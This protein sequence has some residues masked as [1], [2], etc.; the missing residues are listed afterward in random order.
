MHESVG[1]Y[2]AFFEA[3]RSRLENSSA[4]REGWIGYLYH[5]TNIE[6]AVSILQ[7][8]LLLSRADVV[9]HGALKRDHADPGVISGTDR[10]VS[11]YVRLY[12]RPR[13][14]TFFHNEGFRSQ[15]LRERNRFNAH[16]PVPVAL[17]FDAATV[18]AL[19]Q[20]RFSDGN[21]ATW[22]GLPLMS[23]TFQG[24]AALESLP[25]EGIYHDDI[26]YSDDPRKQEIIR[27]RNSEVIVPNSLS[28][29]DHLRA[30][31][32]RSDA[33]LRTLTSLSGFRTWERYRKRT[34]INTDASI[35]FSRWLFIERVR[36]VNGAVALNIH[37][38]VE[39]H[40]RSQSFDATITVEFEDGKTLA[41]TFKL[42]P[43]RGSSLQTPT[44]WLPAAATSALITI[45]LDGELAYR[46]WHWLKEDSVLTRTYDSGEH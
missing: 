33:E 11:H 35:F 31:R 29:T 38:P 12:F 24:L 8:G 32:C 17:I 9:T 44:D 39:V 14:P 36:I 10:D 19:P 15:A 1:T 21:L 22:T 26:L 43:E 41:K 18:L 28:L 7:S 46:A 23:R 3:L 30:I 6:N 5:V 25:F 34:G 2:R 40:E 13:T 42:K 16:C 20:T 27:Q 45:H 37:Q 4:V